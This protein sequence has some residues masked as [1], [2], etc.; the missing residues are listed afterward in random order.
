MYQQV[1]QSPEPELA[2]LARYN[3]GCLSVDRAKQALGEKPEDAS[4]EARAQ[5][6]DHLKA[7]TGYFR[8]CIEMDPE[9]KDA[10]RNLEVLRA[11]TKHMKSLWREKDR[12]KLRDSMDLTQ[13][14]KWIEGQEGNAP[15]AA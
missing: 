12:Q 8:D 6:M 9:C 10:R 15:R 7:A 13:F 3:L 4:P 2:V 1:A 14:L 11:W 5:G